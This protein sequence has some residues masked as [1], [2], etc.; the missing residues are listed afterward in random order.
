MKEHLTKKRQI[1]INFDGTKANQQD[2]QADVTA[3]FDAD[4]ESLGCRQPAISSNSSCAT[5]VCSVRSKFVFVWRSDGVGATG[6][7]AARQ[8]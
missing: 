1:T 4:Q 3:Y 5:R 2:T 6:L 7:E 8:R